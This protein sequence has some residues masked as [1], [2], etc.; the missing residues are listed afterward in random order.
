MVVM[1]RKK[2]MSFEQFA[3][4]LSSSLTEEMGL[5]GEPNEALN[6]VLSLLTMAMKGQ[7]SFSDSQ[8]RVASSGKVSHPRDTEEAARAQALGT[9]DYDVFSYRV[10]MRNFDHDG[11]ISHFSEEYP[12]LRGRALQLRFVQSWLGDKNG[13]PGEKIERLYSIMRAN[14]NMQ[15]MVRQNFYAID[16]RSAAIRRLQQNEWELNRMPVDIVNLELEVTD[17]PRNTV[18]N[19]GEGYRNVADMDLLLTLG[20]DAEAIFRHIGN[21]VWS[22]SFQ[23]MNPLA[24]AMLAMLPEKIEQANKN[25]GRTKYFGIF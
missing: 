9:T 21:T 23:E 1:A 15:K 20:G 22:R 25:F 16:S 2:G 17:Q 12:A 18:R 10:F 6:T 19:N 13:E 11:N 7:V 24:A 4:S 8:V 5:L 14:Q 3:S